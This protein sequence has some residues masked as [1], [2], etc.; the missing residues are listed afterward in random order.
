MLPALPSQKEL[1]QIGFVLQN[2]H[3]PHRVVYFLSLTGASIPTE[4]REVKSEFLCFTVQRGKKALKEK[5][6]N[7]EVEVRIAVK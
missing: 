5:T 1:P 4:M 2:K 3:I 7:S 6:T